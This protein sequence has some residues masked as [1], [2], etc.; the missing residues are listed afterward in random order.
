MDWHSIL[1]AM[2]R[3][4]NCDEKD[5]EWF[6]DN[7]GFKIESFH[8]VKKCP[9]LQEIVDMRFQMKHCVKSIPNYDSTKFEKVFQEVKK[10]IKEWDD[11]VLVERT[12]EVISAE[13]DKNLLE[14]KDTMDKVQILRD[15]HDIA[16]KNEKVARARIQ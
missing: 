7:Y 11:E 14:D 13:M 1:V 5:A 10:Q 12:T 6:E 4:T 16:V 9:M 3:Y 15:E 8:R 2:E